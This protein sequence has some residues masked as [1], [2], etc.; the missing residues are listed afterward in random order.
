[1]FR[2]DGCGKNTRPG[3]KCTVIST[4]FRR[5]RYVLHNREVEG[6]EI[7]K[8]GQFCTTCSANLP[9]P[10]IMEDRAK[11]VHQN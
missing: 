4:K 8:E 2:C 3:E 7:A 6:T 1:M 10:Q 11:I 5:V 9:E